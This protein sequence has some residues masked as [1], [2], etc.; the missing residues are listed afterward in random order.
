MKTTMWHKAWISSLMIILFTMHLIVIPVTASTPVQETMVFENLTVPVP[1]PTPV[2]SDERI[3][4]ILSQ[5]NPTTIS[6]L[7]EYLFYWND[8]MAWNLTD[9]EIYNYS[10]QL[11]SSELVEVDDSGYSIP[12]YPDFQSALSTL[13]KLS[14]D[15]TI[16]FVQTDAKLHSEERELLQESL[17]QSLQR[18]ITDAVTSVSYVDPETQ[19]APYAAGTIYYLYIFTNFEQPGVDGNWTTAHI[20]DALD[21]AYIGTHN[22]KNQAPESANIINSGGYLTVSVSGS[23]SGF[24]D[25][26][27]E[28]AYNLGYRDLN[29]D[30]RQS[31]EMARAY[32][33]ANN[34]DSIVIIYFTHDYGGAYATLNQGYGEKAVVSYW[35]SAPGLV[36]DQS[37][38]ESYQHEA[39][40]LFGA[41]DEYVGGSCPPDQPSGMAVSPMNLLYTNTNHHNSP[42]HDH[43]SVMCDHRSSDRIS[44][45]TRKFIGWGDHD[46][47]GILDPFDSDLM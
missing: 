36:R 33:S 41:A 7:T 29:G 39:L 10:E 21:D 38:P 2:P 24:G 19:S 34:A 26:L 43:D 47:D 30:T 20:N 25:W 37:I 22:I 17:S 28:A 16:Q 4:E 46:S 45:S 3:N 13:L 40:H 6:N 15:Q 14:S 9:A 11:K 1:L 32:Q 23:N 5:D 44:D 35:G 12:N 18:S 27:E 8:K 31:D 42:N